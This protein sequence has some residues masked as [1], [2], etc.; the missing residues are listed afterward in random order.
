MAN[1]LFK[2]LVVAKTQTFS[3]TFQ[4]FKNRTIPMSLGTTDTTFLKI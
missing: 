1:L 4:A 3:F 2:I